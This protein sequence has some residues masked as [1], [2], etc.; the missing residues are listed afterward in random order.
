MGLT[1]VEVRGSGEVGVEVTGGGGVM[2]GLG[3]VGI[4]GGQGKVRVVE[5]G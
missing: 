1:G 4:G 3:V 2:L 5:E